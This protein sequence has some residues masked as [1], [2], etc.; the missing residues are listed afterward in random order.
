MKTNKLRQKEWCTFEAKAS[1]NIPK[2][3]RFRCP[4][5][6]KRFLVF[7]RECGC[8]SPPFVYNLISKHKREV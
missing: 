1:D 8:C 4:K 7:Q 6:K 3:K 5:C 2:T